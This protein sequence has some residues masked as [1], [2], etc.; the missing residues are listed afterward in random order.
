MLGIMKQQQFVSVSR[1]L[2]E[3]G[4]ARVIYNP[5][6]FGTTSLDGFVVRTL[7]STHLSA[8][9]GGE[10]ETGF[11]DS[12]K[13]YL[14]RI[15]DGSLVKTWD[16][17]NNYGTPADDGFGGIT[18]N[19]THAWISAPN[20]DTATDTQS[21]VIY[22]YQLSDYSLVTTLSNPNTYGTATSDIFG[23]SIALSNLYAI[24]GVPNDDDLTDYGVAYVYDASDGTLIYTFTNPNDDT[25]SKD[26]F[27]GGDVAI[28]DDYAVVAAT[29]EDT[30]ATSATGRV[31]V[32]DLSDGSL[33][34]TL[35]SPSPTAIGRFGIS[36][37]LNDTYVVVGA[38]SENSNQGRV[39]VFNLSDGSLNT[40]LNNP[41]V[42]STSSSDSFGNGV[43]ISDNYLAVSAGNED[44]PG[45]TDAGIVYIYQLS[46]FT[47]VTN[48]PDPNAV[49]VA[50]NDFIR[51]QDLNDEYM[52]V[53]SSTANAG[54]GYN[55]V[56]YLYT[57]AENEKILWALYRSH[58]TSSSS[59]ITIPSA[60]KSGDLAVLMDYSTST[61]DTTPSG[62]T[63]INTS[64]TTDIRVSSSY[65]VLVSGDPGT[66][67][68]GMAGTTRKIL[69]VFSPNKPIATVTAT[70]TGSEATVNNPVAQTLSLASTSATVIGFA[71]YAASAAVSP[72]TG[73]G[74]VEI[75]GADTRQYAKYIIHNTGRTTANISVDMDDEGTNGLQSF[76]I[77]LT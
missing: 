56:G 19:E 77:N 15:S 47:R 1:V 60:A 41:N 49:G 74:M 65:K 17:P 62:F 13:A 70:S 64:T 59:T 12:G 50:A 26:D 43:R 40:T 52:L 22:I 5:N 57:R 20:E 16:N 9:A 2:G 44:E 37:D 27:F 51:V 8:G 25:G 73:T 63:Q 24:V 29:S 68:T 38:D 67:I 23:S 75:I 4:L 58:A 53:T 35:T 3:Y 28:S 10:D 36:V 30:G 66:S 39:Y 18:I 72:R 33:L 61:T 6:P 55:S 76:Y 69:L 45:N 7:N 21:G 32:Y 54:D 48:L 46:D 34:Y 11:N 31:Y 71:H 14:F 42:N